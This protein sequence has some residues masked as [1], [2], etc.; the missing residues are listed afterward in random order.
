MPRP[1]PRVPRRAGQGTHVELGRFALGGLPERRV[2]VYVPSRYDGWKPHR[3]LVLFD[4]QNVFGDQGS[5]AGGWH[6]DEAIERLPKKLQPPIVVAIDHGGEARIDEL[7]PWKGKSGRGGDLDRLLDGVAGVLVPEIHRRWHVLPGAVGLCLGGSSLGGL[8]ALYGHFRAPDVFGGALAMS[9]SLWVAD[10]KIFPF[11]EARPKP[12][13]TRIY[14]DCGVR[15]G[16][17]MFALAEAMAA[18][19]H[20]RGWHG[21]RSLMWRPDAKGAHS[22]AHW[23]RRLPK[24]LRFLYA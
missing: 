19:L 24:A 6:A 17:G 1:R 23:R 14:L 3:A 12:K 10:R 18:L 20:A 9:P 7:V 11:V 2:R 13:F 4:G 16:R 15:E 22:E 21:D 5:F 8:A